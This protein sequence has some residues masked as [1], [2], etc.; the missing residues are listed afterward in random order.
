[1]SIELKCLQYLS[2]MKTKASLSVIWNISMPHQIFLIIFIY[3]FI[4]TNGEQLVKEWILNNPFVLSANLHGGSLVA[5]YHICCGYFLLPFCHL[6][7]L[8]P[9]TAFFLSVCT[10]FR[11]HMLSLSL[12]ENFKRNEHICIEIVF[13]LQK[14]SAYLDSFW[15]NHFSCFLAI[16]LI[17]RLLA[18]IKWAELRIMT[19]FSTLLV[20][21]RIIT[22]RCTLSR[23]LKTKRFVE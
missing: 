4:L 16:L 19:F 22:K 13:F 11:N 7:I 10:A 9:L 20:L 17:P 14:S 6:F 8:F 21:I 1:M 18:K 15:N 12:K 5:R 2:I 23:S 3:L